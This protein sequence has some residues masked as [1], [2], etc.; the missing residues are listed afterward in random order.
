MKIAVVTDS[1]C[2]LVPAQ[3]EKYGIYILPMPFQIGEKEYL[4]GV[5]LDRATFFEKQKEEKILR[6]LSHLCRC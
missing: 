1:N 3:G 2:G 4:E 6:P 5:S